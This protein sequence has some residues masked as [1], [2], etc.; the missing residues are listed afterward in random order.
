[1]FPV[2]ALSAGVN[3]DFCSHTSL[4]TDCNRVVDTNLQ[5]K[6]LGHGI[7]EQLCLFS[8]IISSKLQIGRATIY[9]CQKYDFKTNKDNFRA[10]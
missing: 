7:L 1:M 4:N 2:Y 5:L 3:L 10:L 6:G 8:L 9:Y